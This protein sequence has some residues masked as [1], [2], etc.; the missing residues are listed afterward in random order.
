M[1]AAPLPSISPLANDPPLGLI[2]EAKGARGNR[3]DGRAKV[4]MDP[5]MSR[6]SVDVE[7][8]GRGRFLITAAAE[9]PTN[10]WR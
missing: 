1:S 9:S 3:G 10:R 5:R 8:D 7:N 2:S 6:T 4:V